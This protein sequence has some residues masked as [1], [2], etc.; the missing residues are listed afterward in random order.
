M[1]FFDALGGKIKK[2]GQSISQSTKNFADVTKY[3]NS[4]SDYEK[5]ITERYKLVGKSYYER[6]KNDPNSEE[7]MNI[8]AI[9]S[10]FKQINDL[11]QIIK[12]IEFVTKCPN[13]G[14]NVPANALFCNNCGSKIL[15][16][17][18]SRLCSN[19]GKPLAEGS[20]FC[21]EC[22]TPVNQETEAE[23][24]SSET[25]SIKQEEV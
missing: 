21:A 22:G 4:I 20:I 23:E 7:K 11:K 16:E 6:H 14:S 19:C 8:D 9:N 25:L 3:K 13:C 12:E 24:S 15:K 2:V 5:Q 18:T 17:P 10:L 1:A